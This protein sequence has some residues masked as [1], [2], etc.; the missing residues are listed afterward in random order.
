MASMTSVFLLIIT[1]CVN[2]GKMLAWYLLARHPVWSIERTRAVSCELTDF[3]Q[4]QS[5]S[6]NWFSGA[7]QYYFNARWYDPTLGRFITEDPAR[8]GDNW[9]A[10]CNNNPLGLIDPSGL[11]PFTPLGASSGPVAFKTF[12]TGSNFWNHV[13]GGLAG[14]ANVLATPINAGLALA[15]LADKGYTAVTGGRDL[16]LDTVAA[17]NAVQSAGYPA[18]AVGKMASEV[19]TYAR[20]GIAAAGAEETGAALGGAYG[21]VEAAGGQVHHMPADSISPLSKDKGPAIRMDTA[22]HMKTASWGSSKEAQAYRDTQESL[23]NQG[24]FKEAQK[25][26]IN[27][28]QSK[29]GSKY[30]KG[31]DQMKSY[32]DQLKLLK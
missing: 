29:F 14:A 17:A 24:Q 8:S 12:D 23:I 11:D 19:I 30:N 20:T 4:T 28:V 10:F 18:G 7:G 21:D 32:T 6:S 26:D 15:G 27:D 25:M 1:K 3:G 13:V 22:D 31:I 2:D 16:A 9:F 5:C